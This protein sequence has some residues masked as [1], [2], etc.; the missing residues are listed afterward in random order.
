MSKR[1]LNSVEIEEILNVI[2]L[3]RGLPSE[4]A[5]SI[6]KTQ[7]EKIRTQLIKVVIYPDVIPSLKLEIERQ[8][9]KT[10]IQS[11]E[12]VGIIT[13]QSIG[14]RQTQSTLNSFHHAGISMKTTITG[15]PRFSELLNATKDPKAESC[16]VYFTE[17]FNDISAMRKTLNHSL[18]EIKMSK[19][20]EGDYSININKSPEDLWYEFY[21]IIYPNDRSQYD[22][23]IRFKLNNSI[24][25]EYNLHSTLISKKI[26][27]EYE[28][29]KCSTSP[30][31]IGVLD[32]YFNVKLDNSLEYLTE[33]E[34][35]IKYIEEILIPAVYDIKISDGVN[36]ITEIFPEKRQGEWIVETEGSNLSMLMCHDLVDKVRTISNNMWEIFSTLGIEATRNFLIEEFTD[37]VSS[38]GTYVNDSHIKLLVDIMTYNGTITSISRYGLKK[39][40]C[41]PLAKASFEESLENFTKAGIYGEVE[42][43]KGV[44][45][46]VMLGKFTKT[47]S[48]VCDI[49]IDI[50]RLPMLL[51][52]VVERI[53]D[54]P[55]EDIKTSRII[56]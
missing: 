16:T 25:W 54:T 26:E 55:K 13:A 34:N 24:L 10:K 14:E 43:I 44:S 48:G 21:D 22:N 28:D 17:K 9:Y 46:S 1:Q 8:Y 37:V 33:E 19:V 51:K 5:T 50:P 35:M 6:R 12:A 52:D 31:D 53:E 27:N 11:G 42:K 39:E 29:I 3:N 41:G 49:I 18:V 7:Q 47:G 32:L 38:D 30:E 2:P 23:Y 20:V 36:K 15:V 4:V 56:F 45:A 40:N